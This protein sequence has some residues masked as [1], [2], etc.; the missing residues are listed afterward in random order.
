MARTP[1]SRDDALLVGGFL[2]YQLSYCAGVVSRALMQELARFRLRSAEWRLMAIIGSFAPLSTRDVLRHT[3]MEKTQVS[4]AAS[5]L[6]ARGYVV[7]TIDPADRRM[8][9]L[10]FSARGRQLYRELTAR[11][12]VFEARLLR[13]CPAADIGRVLRMLERLRDAASGSQPAA[14]RR[15][16]A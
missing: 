8:L 4:R 3:A 9:V 5:S 2:P 11:A 7:R 16:A 15:R 12:R 14:K 10:T 6:I 13:G 1:P